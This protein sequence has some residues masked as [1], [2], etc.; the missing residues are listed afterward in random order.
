MLKQTVGFMVLR[1]RAWCV[2]LFCCWGEAASVGCLY[3]KGYWGLVSV[4]I[5]MHICLFIYVCTYSRQKD[6]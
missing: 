5:Y 3:S 6:L 4:Y 1:G 2:F